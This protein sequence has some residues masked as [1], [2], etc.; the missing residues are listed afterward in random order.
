[1][2]ARSRPQHA[3]WRPLAAGGDVNF[4]QV[5]PHRS[6]ILYVADQTV[7][8]QVELFAGDLC[9]IGDG[10]ESANVQVWAAKSP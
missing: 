10:F 7:D 4:V 6:A 3:G 1:M 5:M 2:V 9:F 8:E